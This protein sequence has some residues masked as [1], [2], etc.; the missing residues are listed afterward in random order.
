MSKGM[1]RLIVK[2]GTK[3]IHDEWHNAEI[4]E[5]R[6]LTLENAGDFGGPVQLTD[7]DYVLIGDRGEFT[8]LQIGRPGGPLVLTYDF[9][10]QD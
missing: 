9:K 7:D 1:V 8:K 5:T 2:R 10:Q 6:L 3:V 4:S